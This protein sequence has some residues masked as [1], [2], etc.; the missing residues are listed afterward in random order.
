MLDDGI[1]K[2]SEVEGSTFMF[3]G[4]SADN[5]HLLLQC[6]R[7]LQKQ[8]AATPDDDCTKR[9][10]MRDTLSECPLEKKNLALYK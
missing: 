2:V 6:L 8:T 4:T 10:R 5:M 9:N 1:V 7:L 3:K